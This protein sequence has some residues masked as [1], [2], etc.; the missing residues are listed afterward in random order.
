[1]NYLLCTDGQKQRLLPPS[2]E[3]GHKNVVFS[4]IK[5]FRTVVSI[6]DQW[7]VLRGLF[8]EPILGPLR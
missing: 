5:H 4:K 1:L 6:D 7:E 3:R 8:E 2:Y